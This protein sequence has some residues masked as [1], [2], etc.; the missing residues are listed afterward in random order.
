[1]IE[2]PRMPRVRSLAAVCLLL[3]P[4]AAW[5]QVASGPAPARSVPAATPAPRSP[6]GRLLVVAAPAPGPV[7]VDGVLDE[8]VWRTAAPV[9]GFVQSE[10]LDG[11]PA[12]ERTEVRVASDKDTLYIAASLSRPCS[13]ARHHLANPQGLHQLGIRTRSRSSSTRSPTAGTASS[14]STNRAGARSDQ[15]VANEG[16]EINA[17]WDAVWFV[18][19][20]G[21][22][23]GWT[24]EMA[25]P[26]KSLRF[27]RGDAPTL[28][29]QFQPADP[30][31]RTKS[32]TGR[33]SRAPTPGAR[34]RSR[35]T[36]TACRG[37]AGP[38]SA[39]QAVPDRRGRSRDRGGHDVRRR[40]NGRARRQVRRHA[41]ADA[42]RHRQPGLRPGRSRRAQVNLT[43][44]STFYPEKREFFLEN[45][46]IV[47]RRRLRRAT[48][49]L[50][51]TPTPDEDLLLFHSRRI[52]L[53]ADGTPHRSTAAPGSPDGAGLEVG[54]LTIQMRRGSGTTPATNYTVL[55][56]GGI[57]RR[58]PTSVASS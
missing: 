27:E 32:T 28:G 10:P 37:V 11:Q 29:H 53:D 42:R 1:M 23:D 39:D 36:S 33:R 14:S 57:Q 58:V 4:A 7:T 40:R 55:R 44:F 26:F 38:Q 13:R 21:M 47:L 3:I 45:S 20:A 16:R 35:A 56:P 46:G 19:H 52:G 50:S 43:Q 34:R 15:Q 9:S 31:G 51:V 8:D 22:P 54:L 24:V 48:A 49:G 41:R 2:T 18:R 25:I 5:A 17:S 6:D 12:T 30:R